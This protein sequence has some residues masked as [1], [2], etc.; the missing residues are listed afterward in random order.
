M[1]RKKRR[2]D[3]SQS[4]LIVGTSQESPWDLLPKNIEQAVAQ[5]FRR[6]V[7]MRNLMQQLFFAA[8]NAY[9]E[10]SELTDLQQRM[11]K[12]RSPNAEP[13]EEHQRLIDDTAAQMAYYEDGSNALIMLCDA[14]LRRLGR[15]SRLH[16]RD[17]GV[18][19]FNAVRLSE[20]IWALANRYRHISEWRETS[21]SQLKSNSTFKVLIK[22]DLDPMK[23]DAASQ[24]LRKV[25]FRS[26]RAFEN[27]LLSCAREMLPKGVAVTA[28]AGST[29]ITYTG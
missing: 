14:S 5:Y 24:V 2:D 25:N 9:E 26:Y 22:L 23:D 16:P 10:T 3:G 18:E 20:A 27:A 29:S 8:K 15:S 19:A 12:E 11:E 6:V 28:T 4:L 13:D 21:L 1:A 7:A 17:Y